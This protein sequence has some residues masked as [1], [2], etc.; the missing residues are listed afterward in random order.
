MINGGVVLCV[1]SLGSLKMRL[2]RVN[3]LRPKDV[4][5]VSQNEKV[6]KARESFGV[7]YPDSIDRSI[8]LFEDGSY[9]RCY[10]DDRIVLVC[11]P[12]PE[13]KT[14]EQVNEELT[15]LCREFLIYLEIDSWADSS[16]QLLMDMSGAAH[17]LRNALDSYY[18]VVDCP[19]CEKEKKNPKSE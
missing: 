12:W 13:G 18:G 5:F 6:V 19:G 16:T 10:D 11:R 4:I 9:L 17:R 14:V 2:I 3:E 15:K 7:S 1:K 8:V